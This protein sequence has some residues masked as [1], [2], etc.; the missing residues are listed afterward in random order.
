MLLIVF[1][2]IG[3]F[4]YQHRRIADL[5]KQLET[6][7]VN[8]FKLVTEKIENSPTT[9]QYLELQ[10]QIKQNTDNLTGVRQDI[11]R[12][13]PG[14]FFE[15]DELA[16]E[17]DHWAV[18]IARISDAEKLAEADPKTARIL[19]LTAFEGLG[20]RCRSRRMPYMA[21]ARVQ[22][23]VE[24]LY[25]FEIERVQTDWVRVVGKNNGC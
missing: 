5:E 17:I 25:S 12:I 20:I 15:A 4:A 21:I 10:Q 9:S 7:Q 14:G 3:S 11:K 22:P 13:H 2:S 8:Q 24:D 19:A 23:L 18:F 16:E 6:F 1:F